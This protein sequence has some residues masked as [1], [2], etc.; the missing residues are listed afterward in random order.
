V[1][2]KVIEWRDVISIEE[3]DEVSKR[4]VEMERLSCIV[5]SYGDVYVQNSYPWL[6]KQWSEYLS[7]KEEK[8]GY[9]YTNN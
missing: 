4:D 2:K 3:G 5:T 9:K 7:R 6:K 1:V 8:E